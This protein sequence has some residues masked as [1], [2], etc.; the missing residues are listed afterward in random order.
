MYNVIKEEDVL[1]R[2]IALID[3]DAFFVGCEKLLN[4]KLKHKA[5]CVLSNN[6][7]CVVSRSKLAKKVGVKMGMPYFMAREQ[8]PTVIYLSGNLEYYA[9]V[10]QKVMECIKQFSPDVE[11]YSID[12]AFVDLTGTRKLYKKDYI[13]IVEMIKQDIKKKTGI[14]VSIGLSTSKTL[15]KLASDKAKT[16][17]GIYAIGKKLDEELQNTKIEEVWGIGRNTANLL[18]RYGISRVSDF[19]KQNDDWI[20]I[21]LGKVGLDLKYE[22]LGNCLSSVD[23]KIKKPKSVQKTAS[24]K[25]ATKNENEIKN[26]I[27]SHIHNACRKLR[28]YDGYCSTIALMLRTKDFQTYYEKFSIKYPTNFELEVSS[29]ISDLFKKIYLPD[30]LYRSCGVILSDITYESGRQM[31]LFEDMKLQ[32]NISLAKTI[33]II[34]E[35][36]GRNAIKNGFLKPEKD[37]RR[38]HE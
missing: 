17:G 11:V 23:V 21:K 26:A 16:R 36:Y 20:K 38:I 4:P 19:V 14:D 12:E 29:I 30:I 22:L 31:S 6:D 34:E 18:K 37:T 13:E 35:K 32:K 15:A 9:Q 27:N 5:V 8:F 2:I 1:K 24:F 3:C 7:G 25:H 33:S 28:E 10:S